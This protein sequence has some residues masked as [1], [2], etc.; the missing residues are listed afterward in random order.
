MAINLTNQ[1]IDGKEFEEIQ[2]GLLQDATLFD[3]NIEVSG[4]FKS[5]SDVYESQVEVNPKAYTGNS[6]V[7]DGSLNMKVQKTKVVL[8]ELE[9]SDVYSTKQL[10]GTRFEKTMPEGAMNHISEE[11][12]RQVLSLVSPSIANNLDSLAWNGATTATKTAVAAIGVGAPPLLSAA[13]KA[14]VAAMPTSLFDSFAAK[15]IYNNS[16][17][18][19]VPGAGVAD[20]PRVLVTTA[21][22]ASNIEA[23]Y[24]KLYQI[25]SPELLN[26]STVTPIIF[27]PISHKKL[28]ISANRTTASAL[29]QPFT[30]VGEEYYFN[31]VKIV[32][33]KLPENFMI[34]TASKFLKLL[35]DS[36]GDQSMIKTDFESNSSENIFYKVVVAMNTWVTNQ[37]DIFIY[38][39]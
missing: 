32:F 5:A 15:V 4:G 37:K 21:I 36:E 9:Y 27:A 1:Q 8:A 39:A 7:A 3:G 26:S 17:S 10:K 28:I 16:Q 2:A 23:E 31:D 19:A 38:V 29:L 33:R 24:D 35:I 6:V 11:F 14:A 20:C 12:D 22:T 25:A 30:K 13:Q 18:K 34:L